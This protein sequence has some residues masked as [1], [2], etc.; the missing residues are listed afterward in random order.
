MS[1]GNPL[2]SGVRDMGPLAARLASAKRMARRAP[3]RASDIEARLNTRY[4]LDTLRVPH[5][6]KR[7]PEDWR[8]HH[9]RLGRALGARRY[10]P[11]TRYTVHVLPVNAAD[12]GVPQVRH[13]VFTVGVREDLGID[14][15]WPLPRYSERALLRDQCSGRYWE[16]H[17]LAARP[18]LLSRLALA[19]DDGKLPWRTLRDALT[20]G[21]PLPEPV[22]EDKVETPGWLH[23][24]RWPGARIYPGHTPNDLD[25][26]AKTVK[27]GVHG[28]PGGETVVRLDDGGVRYLTVREVA[29]VMTFPDR[30][31]LAG[32]RGEQMRQLGNAVPVRLGAVMAGTLADAMRPELAAAQ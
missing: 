4:T 22:A 14:W 32:P 25:R 16:R 6:A 1:P 24:A 26:P 29:R 28:V 5:L 8:A 31:R 11:M 7:S 3:I 23:H 21:R 27:A 9:A 30:W 2:K 10:D 17:D 12:Y 13:R 18:D 20:E 15:N 19:V